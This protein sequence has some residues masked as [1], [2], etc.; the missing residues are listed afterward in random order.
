MS[1]SGEFIL[2][3]VN[4]CILLEKLLLLIDCFC[5]LNVV[6]C[7]VPPEKLG[8]LNAIIPGDLLFPVFDREIPVAFYIIMGFSHM[9]VEFL[10]VVSIQI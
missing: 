7:L 8:R 3:L 2:L 9:K 10:N 6:F 1:P 5:I 4:I